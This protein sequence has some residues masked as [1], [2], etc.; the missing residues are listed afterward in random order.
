MFLEIATTIGAL[1]GALVAVYIPVQ[2]IAVL[3]GVISDLFGNDVA[4]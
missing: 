3:F 4:A 2:Y 1:V